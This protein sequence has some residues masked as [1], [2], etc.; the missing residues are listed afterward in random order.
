MGGGIARECAA[1]QPERVAAERASPPPLAGC[2]SLVISPV[3]P[4][5]SAAP[6]ALPPLV[7]LTQ[8]GTAPSLDPGGS[9]LVC[10][11]P[12][13]D[14]AGRPQQPRPF[15]CHLCCKSFGFH[16]QLQVHLRSHTKET[17]FRCPHCLKGFS[18]KGNYNR[19]LRIHLL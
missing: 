4:P 17:P 19:H 15:A 13:A 8:L 6:E 1:A 3:L 16:S 9:G 7:T 10:P 5:H 2:P 12:G 18:Q 14:E 11:G